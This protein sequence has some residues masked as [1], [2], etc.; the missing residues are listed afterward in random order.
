MKNGTSQRELGKVALEDVKVADFSWILAGPITTLCLAH[1]GATVVRVESPEAPDNLRFLPPLRAEGGINGSGYFAYLNANKYSMS[2]NLK[3]P[4]GLEVA[5][6]LVAWAD[7]VVEN[8]SPGTMSRLGLSYEDLKKI[9]DDII[10]LSTSNQGQTGPHAHVPGFGVQLTSFSGYTEITGWPDREPSPPFGGYTDLLAPRLAVAALMAALDFRNKT[11]KGIYLDLSQLEAAVYFLN[12]LIQD[13]IVN[14]TQIVRK[15]NRSSC[16]VPHGV[17]W[18]KGDD[19][20]CA[21]A[22]SS[23]QEWKAFCSVIGKPDLADDPKFATLRSRKEHE[24]E[25]DQI[26]ESWTINLGPEEVMKAMQAAGVAAGVVQTSKDLC[27]DVQ[28]KEREQFWVLEH[29]V[30]G[31][32]LHVGPSSKLEKTPAE[33]RLP[34]P[35]LGQHTKYVCQE[36]LGL[37]EQQFMQLMKEGVFG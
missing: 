1:Y 24:D 28:L 35:C 21:I 4:K 29:P 7:I 25:L 5:R 36:I 30:I 37:T 3:H 22:V 12:P 6:K 17:Y 19:R 13:S 20:W 34:A 9:K 15:G 32:C 27:E 16:A 26:T 10:M 2:V 11:G 23:D 33:A 8:F 31:P 18:C 14:K